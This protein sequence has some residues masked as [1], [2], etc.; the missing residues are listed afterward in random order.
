VTSEEATGLLNLQSRWRDAYAITFSDGVWSA[1]RHEAPVT[2]LT[3][4]TAPE[5]RG[6][7]QDD[8]TCRPR[9]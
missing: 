6:P 3:A 8:H 7:M 1:R 5:L 4:D 9:P 2:I